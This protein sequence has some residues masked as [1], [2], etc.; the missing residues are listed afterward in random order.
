LESE[1]ETKPLLSSQQVMA[2]CWRLIW[3]I[4]FKFV[5]IYSQQ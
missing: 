2:F 4:I 5:T 3:F 1:I